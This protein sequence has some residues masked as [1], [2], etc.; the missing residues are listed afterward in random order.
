MVKYN[1]YN[2]ECG[3]MKKELVDY[4]NSIGKL[5]LNKNGGV[6][7]EDRLDIRELHRCKKGINRF[8]FFN[9]LIGDN[10][11]VV[12]T[13]FQ[14][15]WSNENIM[16]VISGDY[17]NSVGV[18]SVKAYPVKIIQTDPSTKKKEMY[19]SIATHNLYNLDGVY[20]GLASDIL[21]DYRLNDRRKKEETW[22]ILTQKEFKSIFL[23]IMTED[24]FNEWVNLFLADTLGTY[25][26]RHLCN[27][28]FYKTKRFG[29]WEGVIAIDNERSK[30]AEIARSKMSEDKK[31]NALIHN[32]GTAFSPLQCVVQTSHEDNIL[33]IN[34]LLDKGVF[35][36]S[37][38]KTIKNS[39]EYPYAENMKKTCDF[40]GINCDK[41]YELSSRL[42]EY[43]Q[44]HLM[45]K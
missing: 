22:E 39:L 11:M 5:G 15:D 28:F 24:C 30:L 7:M 8:N 37:Q 18:S 25:K 29:K 45:V 33:E 44:D 26:D 21:Y 9:Y 34:H 36:E 20:I 13:E 19:P 42:E 12:K 14:D 35:G 32:V 40:Y 17:F 31:Y 10:L 1:K 3:V 38:I 41:M 27:Y 2:G 6:L 16:E 43:N 23:E 4:F